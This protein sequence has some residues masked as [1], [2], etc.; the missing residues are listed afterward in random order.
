MA[1]RR[2]KIRTYPPLDSV[3]VRDQLGKGDGRRLLVSGIAVK[4]VNRPLDR[5]RYRQPGRAGEHE[6]LMMARQ[7]VVEVVVI[8]RGKGRKPVCRIPEDD[9]EADCLHIGFGE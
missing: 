8:L 2:A 6:A 7:R 9:V 4:I 5:R 1:I 3:T